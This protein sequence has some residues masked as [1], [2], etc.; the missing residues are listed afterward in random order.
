MSGSKDRMR[1]KGSSP[2]RLPG[3]SGTDPLDPL[4]FCSKLAHAGRINEQDRAG[5]PA[6]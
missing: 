2:R 4:L 1:I 5:E 6:R 3:S